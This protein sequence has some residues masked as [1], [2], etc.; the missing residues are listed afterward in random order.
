MELFNA[1]RSYVITL[2]WRGA[3]DV[4]PQQLPGF[5]SRCVR[6]RKLD[7]GPHVIADADLVAPVDGSLMEHRP[8]V[9][10]VYDR[11]FSL[12]H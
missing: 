10:K 5:L 8:L 4:V 3:Y 7:S 9:D 1:L 2:T 6:Q 12:E 11:L